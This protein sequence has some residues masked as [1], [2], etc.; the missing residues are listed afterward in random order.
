M[1]MVHGVHQNGRRAELAWTAARIAR[2]ELAACCRVEPAALVAAA[3]FGLEA[4]T[5]ARPGGSRRIGR[6]AGLASFSSRSP[7]PF[8]RLERELRVLESL[9][10]V[11]VL[12]ARRAPTPDAIAAAVELHRPAGS[13]LDGSG[14]TVSMSLGCAIFCKDPVVFSASDSAALNWRR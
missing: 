13:W 6:I 11:D 12:S 1:V 5:L 3:F 4:E 8:R 2:A 10:Q 7:V 14:V 9:Q